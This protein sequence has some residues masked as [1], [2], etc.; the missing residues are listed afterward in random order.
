MCLFPPF[1]SSQLASVYFFLSEFFLRCALISRPHAQTHACGKFGR[2]CGAAHLSPAVLL[3]SRPTASPLSLCH[4]G[5]RLRD[6]QSHAL[7]K[8]VNEQNF[9]VWRFTTVRLFFCLPA[10]ERR[11]SLRLHPRLGT[12][13]CFFSLKMCGFL[14]QL[15]IW[16]TWEY[17]TLCNMSPIPPHSS[18]YSTNSDKSL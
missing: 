17:S 3:W 18:V 9:T 5:G 4:P 1:F 14:S 8:T 2:G 16:N 12:S 15:L 10:W 13:F 6:T 11:R 7:R